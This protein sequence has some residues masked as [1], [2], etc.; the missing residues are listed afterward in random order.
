M[1]RKTYL[2]FQ[3][4]LGQKTGDHQNVATQGGRNFDTHPILGVLKSVSATL[5]S[6]RGP[7]IQSDTGYE[8]PVAY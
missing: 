3:V 2:V 4:H 8:C 7:R 1:D 6:A 5:P